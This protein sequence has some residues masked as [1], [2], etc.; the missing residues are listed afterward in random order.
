MAKI[1]ASNFDELL[2]ADAVRRDIQGKSVRAGFARVAAQ[3]V[4]FVLAVGSTMVLARLL[5]PEAFGLRDM[6]LV[7]VAFV[8]SFRDFGLPLAVANR[9]QID[10]LGM[11]RVFWIN[12]WLN[13]GIVLFMLAMSPLLAWWFQERALLAATP[14]MAASVFA[15][16]ISTQHGSLLTRQMRHDVLTVIEVGSL[17]VGVG[18]AVSLALLGFG[19]WALLWQLAAT[20]IVQS[21]ATW[22]VC[23]WVPAGPR[24]SR[25]SSG[26]RDLFRY[27]SDLTVFRV[28][29]HVG[30][31]LDRFL[32]GR[33]GGATNMGLYG[34]AYQWSLFPLQQ[35][36]TPLLNVAVSGLSRVQHDPSRYRSYFKR[37]M[38]P[39][40]ALIF[41]ALIFMF[42]EAPN[43]VLF[44]LG[45]EW[46]AAI[47]L[48]RVLCVAR[49]SSRA[50]TASPSGFICRK[51]QTQTP[52]ALGAGLHAADDRR[53]GDRR[54]VGHNGR[55]PGALRSARPG[56]PFPASPTAC[57]PPT[58]TRATL[59]KFYGDRP[60]RR[61]RRRARS[62]RC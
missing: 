15:L 21:A 29:T 47:P 53:R 4:Q 17:V 62:S 30:R 24:A 23:G 43:V 25:A 33:F 42:V 16:G 61:W 18:V 1:T 10:H 46:M 57:A 56:S 52:A 12:L 49:R 58:S 59:S 22:V 2:H 9:E 51:G 36:Y 3:G 19:Y 44:V 31:N 27:S 40:Y 37:G 45:D 6:V 39:V 60:S 7:L 38:L 54:A 20:L 41:P 50:S 11:S 8:G 32:V 55:P 5:A 26:L 35:A 28:I 13:V 48:F 14:L 34:R